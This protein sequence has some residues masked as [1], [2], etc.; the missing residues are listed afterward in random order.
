VA[1][2]T[3]R[4]T[5][6]NPDATDEPQMV[7]LLFCAFQQWPA[8]PIEVPPIEHLRWKLRSD[9]IAPRHQ[10]VTEIDQRIAAM[11][12]RILFRVRVR[13]RDY[14][15]REEGDAAVD[16]RYQGRGLY[17]ALLDYIY[18]SPRDDDFSL[19]FWFSTNPRTRRPGRVEDGQLLAN[20]IRV[21]EKPYDARAIVARRREKYG[22]RL[23]ARLAV[24]RI[25]LDK[26]VNRLL[27]PSYLGRP[28][29]EGS[30]ATLERFDDRI[31]G[32]FEEAARPF[33]F[34]VVRSKDYLNWRYCDPAAGRF[35]IRAAEQEG[36]LLGYLVFKVAEGAG[37]IADLLALPGRSDVV[38]SLLED[39]LR[40]FRASGVEQVTCWMILRHPYNAILRRYGFFDSRKDIGCRYRTLSL[41]RSEL[42][43]LRDGGARIHV[44]QGDSDWV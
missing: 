16:P 27:H 30:I 41:D 34:I 43:F 29:W 31:G 6:R 17:R 23:P 38:R 15:A 18:E 12:L 3:H 9:P 42:E 11:I 35:T 24:L 7:E 10:W 21:L 19:T 13:G 26:A 4:A 36:R 14:L 2:E 37:F 44:T 22:G 32:F 28:G 1:E 8:F 25:G 20:P 33:D 39:A 5:I 40:L